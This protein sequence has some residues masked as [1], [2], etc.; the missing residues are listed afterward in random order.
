LF[1]AVIPEVVD[2]FFRI[3]SPDYLDLSYVFFTVE[4]LSSLEI[5]GNLAF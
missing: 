2:K 3:F 4:I 1:W 5:V